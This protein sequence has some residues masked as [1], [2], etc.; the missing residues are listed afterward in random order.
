MNSSLSLPAP[1]GPNGKCGTNE[2]CKSE[3]VCQINDK[4]EGQC[5]RKLSN[6][7]SR[8]NIHYIL[9]LR[10]LT[11]K[12]DHLTKKMSKNEKEI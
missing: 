10:V 4:G 12:L 8:I 3:L 6:A 11:F 9:K 1:K 7:E 5:K 2:E